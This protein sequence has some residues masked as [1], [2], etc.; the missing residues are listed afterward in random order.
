MIQ[1]GPVEAALPGGDVPGAGQFR[2][3]A[4]H[5]AFGATKIEGESRGGRETGAVGAG[6]SSQPSPE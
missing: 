5:L 6:V 3:V 1:I 4:L 2:D